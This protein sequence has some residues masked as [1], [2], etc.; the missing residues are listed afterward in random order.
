MEYLDQDILGNPLKNWIIAFSILGVSYVLGKVIFW[1]FSN[2]LQKITAKTKN[3]LDDIFSGLF[4][5]G[6]KAIDLGLA[7]GIGAIKPILEEKFGKKI[8]IKI[9]S[10]KKSL[11][12]QKYFLLS[13]EQLELELNHLYQVLRSLPLYQNLYCLI[14]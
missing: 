1:I 14:Q 4:W 5:V 6:N 8:K 10:Q 7:D 12:Q 3:K 2:V 13:L 9:I 11:L